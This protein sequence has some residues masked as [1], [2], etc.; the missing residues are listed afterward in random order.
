MFSAQY[1]IKSDNRINAINGAI[2]ENLLIYLVKLET[3]WQKYVY[4][5]TLV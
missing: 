4:L 5:F 1:L 2:V 3:T